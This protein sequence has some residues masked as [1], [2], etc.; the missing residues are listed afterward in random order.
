[1]TNRVLVTCSCGT[2]IKLIPLKSVRQSDASQ[3]S[4]RVAE[5]GRS[6]HTELMSSRSKCCRRKTQ[7]RQ[8]SC[9]TW[10]RIRLGPASVTSSSCAT[11]TAAFRT[12]CPAADDC[13]RDVRDPR[14]LNITVHEA[15]PPPSQRMPQNSKRC[16]S[17]R[18]RSSGSLACPGSPVG[19]PCVWW[20]DRRHFV[21]TLVETFDGLLERAYTLNLRL[22]H[23]TAKNCEMN[24]EVPFELQIGNLE[25][26]GSLHAFARQVHRSWRNKRHPWDEQMCALF[27]RS[28][29]LKSSAFRSWLRK[30]YTAESVCNYTK[31]AVEALAIQLHS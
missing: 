5:A 31:H 2:M 8:P 9:P 12:S 15:P 21:T 11:C 6:Q 28:Y 26:F 27:M 25:R 19:R 7:A 29:R 13:E 30:Y 1:M 3:I 23:C 22:T 18:F 14:C 17:C 16:S 24:D 10:W 20:T 4:V